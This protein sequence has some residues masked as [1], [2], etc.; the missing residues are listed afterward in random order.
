ME[1]LIEAYLE[2]SIPSKRKPG[3]KGR[4]KRATVLDATVEEFA[5]AGDVLKYGVAMEW[6]T[7]SS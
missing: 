4:Q 1:G 7:A 6:V 2:K 5:C 3:R